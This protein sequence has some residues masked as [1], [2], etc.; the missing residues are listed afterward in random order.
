MLESFGG[1][2]TSS[3]SGK[4]DFLLVGKD[5]GFSKVTRPPTTPT[6][7]GC[8]AHSALA[9]TVC[10]YALRASACGTPGVDGAIDALV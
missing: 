1:K 3:V 4:T 6:Q 7:R 5:P 2:V 9:V 10:V 8:L